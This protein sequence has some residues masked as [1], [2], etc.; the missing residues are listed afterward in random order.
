M[1]PS[2][3]RLGAPFDEL[4]SGPPFRNRPSRSPSFSKSIHRSLG[5]PSFSKPIHRPLGPPSFSKPIHRSPGSSSFSKPIHRPLGPPSFSKPIHH[6]SAP[7]S[8]SE[9]N[10]E[11]MAVVRKPTEL[12]SLDDPMLEGLTPSSSSKSH[13]R[14]PISPP[15]HPL[16]SSRQSSAPLLVASPSLGLP[17]LRHIPSCSKPGPKTFYD[18]TSIREDMPVVSCLTLT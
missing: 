15:T 1:P 7:P 6:P 14:P 16:Q 5:S 8:V 9:P 3:C 4:P 12:I 17:D 11:S 10:H 2:H 13:G 18:T